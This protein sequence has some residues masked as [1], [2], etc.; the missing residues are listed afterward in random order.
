MALLGAQRPQHLADAALTDAEHP[1]DRRG[2][3]A[4]AALVLDHPPELGDP[5]G[6]G[7]LPTP[8]GRQG[9]GGVGAAHAD[10]A[11]NLGRVELLAVADLA[12]PP[13]L[14]DALQRAGGRRIGRLDLG[15]AAAGVGSLQPGELVR[16]WLAVAGRL[17]AERRQAWVARSGG[18]QGVQPLPRGRHGGADLA[19]ELGRLQRHPAA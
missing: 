14:L 4:L 3:Q 12:G 9:L 13:C 10:L 1:G 11:G 19:G 15:T 2:V 7:Q 6:V 18:T 8:Q 17:A 5:L 16:G